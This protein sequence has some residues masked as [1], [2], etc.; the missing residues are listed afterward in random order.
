M[1]LDSRLIERIAERERALSA[2][3]EQACALLGYRHAWLC[4]PRVR[5]TELSEHGVRVNCLRSGAVLTLV[6][7]RT[8]AEA[9][10]AG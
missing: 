4:R 5:R 2:P 7:A 10:G 9:G 8:A 3:T 1:V 6:I